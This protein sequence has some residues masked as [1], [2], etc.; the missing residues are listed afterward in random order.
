MKVAQVRSVVL[1]VALSCGGAASAQG[2]ASRYTFDSAQERLSATS[3]ALGAARANADA[4]RSS[5]EAVSGLNLPIVSLDAQ[6]FRYQKTLEVSLD[7]LRNAVGT[8]NASINGFLASLP[9]GALPAGAAGQ[10]ANVGGNALAHIPDSLST[11]ITDNVWR[12]TMTLFWPIYTGGLSG[13]T[14]DAAAAGVRQADAELLAA[15]DTLGVQLVAAYF[16][17]QLA[18]QV[19]ETSRQ[20]LARFELHL[21]N[22]Q[23]M[24]AQGVLSKAQRLQVEVARNAAE[25]QQLRAENDF[26]TAAA[27]LTRLLKESQPIDPAT[28]LFALSAPLGPQQEFVEAGRATSPQLVR[29]QAL[30]DASRSGVKAAQA[31]WLPKVY[32]FGSYNFNASNA[33]LPD[34]DWIVG[35][36]LHYTL[37]SNV[38]RSSSEAAA[39]AR[40]RQ[41]DAAIEQADNDLETVI[42]RSYQGVE[43]ARRQFMLLATNIVAAE[44]NVRVHTLGFREGEASATALIDAQV[45]LSVARTQRAAAAFEYDLALAQLLA[46][47]GQMHQYSSYLARADQRLGAP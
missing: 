29:L 12:P 5:A 15:G 24:E 21:R 33:V 38:D 35:I 13:A 22:A 17:Q 34:P 3:S 10:L 30:R 37:S 45:A 44:E 16:G 28:P 1:A 6:A 19:R 36:G 18:A 40:A 46:A 41:A 2:S 43:T 9:S 26:D 7:A 14:Q 23:R 25:R 39:Q 27:V 31:Q 20:N 4:S 11:T 47:S 8:V 32:G 42:I